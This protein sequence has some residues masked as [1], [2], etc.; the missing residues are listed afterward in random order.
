MV[1][2]PGRC[3]VAGLLWELVQGQESDPRQL[4]DPDSW[5]VGCGPLVRIEIEIA[6]SMH[7]RPEQPSNRRWMKFYFDGKPLHSWGEEFIVSRVYF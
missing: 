6:R 1:G 2:V 7:A 4:C 3:V 5:E